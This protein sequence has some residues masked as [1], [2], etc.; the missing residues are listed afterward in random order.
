[1]ANALQKTTLSD[2]LVWENEQAERHEFYRGEVFAMTGA[3]RAHGEVVGNVFAALKR[4]LK[5]TPCRVYLEG[6]KVRVADDAIFYPDVFVTCDAQDLRTEMIF[7]AP[8]LVVEVLS[9][10]TA[11]FDQG[12]KFTQYRRI[13]SL[14]EY[15]LVSPDGQRVEVYRRNAEGLFVLHDY[16]A[17]PSLLLASVEAEISLQ[18]LFEGVDPDRRSAS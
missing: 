6:M 13:A 18:D 4:Q 7:T 3:R 17:G 12:L 16:T 10:S 8:T 15:V 9:P 2:Y 14:K 5:G 11:G 1:M